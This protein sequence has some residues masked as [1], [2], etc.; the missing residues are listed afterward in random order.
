MKLLAI[1][2]I[3]KLLLVAQALGSYQG[4]VKFMGRGLWRKRKGFAT[5]RLQDGT[6]REAEIHWYEASGIG[7]REFKIKR[8]IDTQS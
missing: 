1:L 4:F 2:G 3:P 8:Y 5:V 7:K 6:L